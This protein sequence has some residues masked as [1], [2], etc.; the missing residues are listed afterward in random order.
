MKRVETTLGTGD[1]FVRAMSTIGYG[2]VCGRQIVVFGGGKVGSGVVRAAR[3]LGA[4]VIVVDAKSV[5][6]PPG[7]EQVRLADMALVRRAIDTAWCVV[8][9]TGV[10]AA[11]DR[12]AADLVAGRALLANLGAEDEFGPRIPPGRVLA[13]KQPLNFVLEEPTRL[14]YLDPV[15]ALSNRA[16]L[17]LTQRTLGPGIHVP[18]PPLEA[19]ILQDVIDRGAIAAEVESLIKEGTV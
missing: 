10:R 12:F 5:P 19:E 13:G 6:V 15:F 4:R 18:P 9:A 7:C 3:R 1:G 14:A 17:V 2:D 8:S 16:A 11:L